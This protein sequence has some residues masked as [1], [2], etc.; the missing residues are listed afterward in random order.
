VCF[1]LDGTIA[2][3]MGFMVAASGLGKVD[4]PSWCFTDTPFYPLPGSESVSTNTNSAWYAIYLRYNQG[5]N[6]FT[7]DERYSVTIACESV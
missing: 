4:N 6:Y 2:A 3:G 7:Y 5:T 1:H